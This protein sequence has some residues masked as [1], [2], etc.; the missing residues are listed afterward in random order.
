[1][2]VA[3][4]LDELKREQER[5]A[6]HIVLHD[7]FK[8]P[9]K[10]IAGFDVAYSGRQACC[11]GVVL[12]YQSMEIL[13]KKAT[14]AEI[15]FP[16]IPTFLAFREA[17]IIIKTYKKIKNKPDILV[18]DGSGI[19]HPRFCGLASHVGVLLN[20]ATIGVTKKLLCGI[21]KGNKI[22]L[23]KELVGWKLG[24]IYISPGHKISP[25]SAIDI[26]KYCMKDHRLPEP[27]Y[28]ADKYA[29]EIKKG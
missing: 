15:N 23:N 25:E 19:C 26:I 21:I 17:F 11:V 6:K 20:V 9:V 29:N 24:N 22:F 7:D 12:D 28:L 5:I 18:L 2:K 13:E 16:Y 1:M 14:Y 27:L 10:T 4:D 8:R 3:I